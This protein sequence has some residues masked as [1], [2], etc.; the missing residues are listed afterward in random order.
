MG[1][2]VSLAW[3]RAG[4]I[5]TTVLHVGRSVT[6]GEAVDTPANGPDPKLIIHLEFDLGSLVTNQRL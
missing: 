3:P 6:V 4:E 1:Q 2:F 5:G